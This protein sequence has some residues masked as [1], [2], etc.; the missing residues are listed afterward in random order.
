ML[1]L[2]GKLA[3]VFTGGAGAA[4]G[5][6]ATLVGVIAA[7]SPVAIFLTSTKSNEIFVSVSYREAAFWGAVIAVNLLVAYLTKRN[8][9]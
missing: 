6:V 5:T 7:L 4:V 3:G 2:L 1:D 8:A 9:A